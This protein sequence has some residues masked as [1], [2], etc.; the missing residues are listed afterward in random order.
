M[1]EVNFSNV[2][3]GAGAF[4]F[5]GGIAYLFHSAIDVRQGKRGQLHAKFNLRRWSLHSTYRGLIMIA[6]GVF[7]LGGWHFLKQSLN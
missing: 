7:L 3:M 6:V 4:L 2:V 5:M 1:D